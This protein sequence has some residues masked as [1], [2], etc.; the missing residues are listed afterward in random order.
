MYDLCRSYIRT[1][2]QTMPDHTTPLLGGLVA[3]KIW[4]RSLSN[5]SVRP[6]KIKGEN[7]DVDV[8]LVSITYKPKTKRIDVPVPAM[9]PQKFQATK[10]MTV[11]SRGG[12]APK[13]SEMHEYCFIP[14]TLMDQWLEQNKLRRVNL[15][16]PP[17]KE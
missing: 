8:E 15:G 12:L 6:V 5:V 7:G 17:L 2:H 9:H 4:K 11:R 13:F 3:S 1:F 10:G 14:K 16:L